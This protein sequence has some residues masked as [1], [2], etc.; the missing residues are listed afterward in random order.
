MARERAQRNGGAGADAAQEILELPIGEIRQLIALMNSSDLEEITIEHHDGLK[1]MLRKPA[2]GLEVTAAAVE[3]EVESLDGASA[4][5]SA[6]HGK[7]QSEAVEIGSPLVGVYRARVKPDDEPLIHPGD[8][9]REGQ[10]VAAVE[11]LNY[12]N[13]IESSAA[14]RVKEIF[15]RDGEPVEF[16]QPLLAIEP[17]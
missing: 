10:V 12:V 16:G 9:V 2:S 8:V 13:E 15:V 17:R 14:G 1:L 7:A 6:A 4:E 5:D 11:A 3:V